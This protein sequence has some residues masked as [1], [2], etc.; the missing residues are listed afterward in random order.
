MRVA[1]VWGGTI[2]LQ[3]SQRYMSSLVGMI[4]WGDQHPMALTTVTFACYH[5]T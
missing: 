3:I 1:G 4:P 2:R 5:L